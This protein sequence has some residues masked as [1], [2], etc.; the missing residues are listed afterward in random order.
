MLNRYIAVE[1]YIQRGD[2]LLGGYI[3][4]RLEYLEDDW[5]LLV[6]QRDDSLDWSAALQQQPP[7]DA[8]HNRTRVRR[9]IAR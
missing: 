4:N 2:N 7:Q 1:R 3:P 8:Q 6:E 9:A 5:L